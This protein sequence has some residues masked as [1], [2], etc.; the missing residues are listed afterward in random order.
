VE[1]IDFL[2]KT[3]KGQIGH[4]SGNL[5]LR[6][7]IP[8]IHLYFFYVYNISVLHLYPYCKYIDA[9]GL[10]PGSLYR[11]IKTYEINFINSKKRKLKL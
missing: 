4:T 11:N 5:Q 9:I 6:L 3:Y 8:N 10:D 7:D 1:T 2:N